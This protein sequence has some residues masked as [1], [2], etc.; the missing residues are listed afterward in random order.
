M[1]PNGLP[2]G[3]F[4][5]ENTEEEKILFADENI[6]KLYGCET[7]EEFLDYTGNS[8]SGMVHPDDLNRI[9]NQISGADYVWRKT[10]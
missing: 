8:F 4:I 3:F 2:G 1:M 5:Y 7:Y 10:P 9:E 6:I